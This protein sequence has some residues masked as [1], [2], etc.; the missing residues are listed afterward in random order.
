MGRGALDIA[1]DCLKA[2][3]T[4]AS[5]TGLCALK[6]MDTPNSL[7]RKR[8]KKTCNHDWRAC[9]EGLPRSPTGAV[10]VHPLTRH[11]AFLCQEPKRVL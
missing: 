4:L 3:P 1:P 10:P 7:R 5:R 2:P 8:A 6:E 9:I 11:R